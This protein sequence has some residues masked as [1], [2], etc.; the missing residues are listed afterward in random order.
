MKPALVLTI[1][2]LLLIPIRAISAQAGRSSGYQT[3]DTDVVKKSIVFLWYPRGDGK[4]EVGTG[5][6]L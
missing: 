2:L 3:I 4:Y 5:F 6:C 1:G